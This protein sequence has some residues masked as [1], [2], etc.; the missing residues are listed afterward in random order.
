LIIIISVLLRGKG[1]L[2]GDFSLQEC[3]KTYFRTCYNMAV[4]LRKAMVKAG[5]KKK[6]D[7]HL[8]CLNLSSLVPNITI[9]KLVRLID[10]FILPLQATASKFVTRGGR[11]NSR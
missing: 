10:P 1:G 4:V 7:I 2:Q 9:F 5:A 6:Q 8:R 3:P 11:L